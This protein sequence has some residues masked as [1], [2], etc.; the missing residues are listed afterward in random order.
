M[1]SLKSPHKSRTLKDSR[2]DI[3]YKKIKEVSILLIFNGVSVLFF[4][5]FMFVSFFQT[6]FYILHAL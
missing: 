4:V 6:N 5:N 1:I 3:E 2:Y